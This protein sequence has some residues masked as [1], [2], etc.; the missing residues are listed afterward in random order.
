MVELPAAFSALSTELSGLGRVE[1]ATDLELRLLA[2]VTLLSLL[3]FV[4]GCLG[5][6]LGESSFGKIFFS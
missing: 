6:F 3:R 4:T 2:L 1:A 5:M